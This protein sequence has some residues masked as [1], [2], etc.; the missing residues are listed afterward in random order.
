MSLYSELKPCAG[1]VGITVLW[2]WSAE[3][4]DDDLYLLRWSLS[5]GAWLSNVVTC[6]CCW[7]SSETR[8]APETAEQT[9]Q[10]WHVLCSKNTARPAADKNLLICWSVSLFQCYICYTRYDFFCWISQMHVCINTL[11]DKRHLKYQCHCHL[12]MSCWNKILK[13]SI[14]S[15][16]FTCAS[17]KKSNIKLKKCI[18][19]AH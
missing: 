11:Q 9:A 3:P 5:D 15:K 6:K 14:F 19:H 7:T 13:I 2:L 1:L 4:D 18:N 17:N 8:R 10:N 16:Q 12:K